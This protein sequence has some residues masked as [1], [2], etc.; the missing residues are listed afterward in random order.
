[1]KVAISLLRSCSIEKKGKDLY[2][3][4]TLGCFLLI[5]LM[6]L[7]QVFCN[8]DLVVLLPWHQVA[9]QYCTLL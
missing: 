4:F 2:G 7:W 1:M 9:M 5:N 8:L 6:Y 3:L